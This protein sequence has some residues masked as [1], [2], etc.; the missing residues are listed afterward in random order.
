MEPKDKTDGQ[1]DGT[2]VLIYAITWL[3]GVTGPPVLLCCYR[4]IS[5]YTLPSCH[6]SGKYT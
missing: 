6:V 3:V 5:R 2:L 4:A 1:V